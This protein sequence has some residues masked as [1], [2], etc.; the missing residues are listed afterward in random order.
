MQPLGAGFTNIHFEIKYCTGYKLPTFWEY[1][2]VEIIHQRVSIRRLGTGFRNVYFFIF[3]FILDISCQYLGNTCQLNSYTDIGYILP[4]IGGYTY[5]SWRVSAPGP[6]RPPWKSGQ[7][8][9]RP[10]LS[11]AQPFLQPKERTKVRK[12]R[13]WRS[14]YFWMRL[15]LLTQ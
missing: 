4:T 14:K 7:L 10:W 15:M 8:V 9:P 2:S 12:I 5:V 13:S 6:N 3:I 1:N 11:R